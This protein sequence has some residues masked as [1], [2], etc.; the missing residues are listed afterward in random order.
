MNRI[1][2][3]IPLLSLLLAACT[4]LPKVCDYTTIQ[5]D[6]SYTY[7]GEMLH[8]RKH[9]Y[10]ILAK[11]DSIVYVGFW[12]NGIRHGKGR[13]TDSR[14]R[15]IQGKFRGD[16]LFWGERKDSFGVYRGQMNACG[17][18]NGHG[19]YSSFD[20]LMYE[21]RWK[22]DKEDGFGFALTKHN[23]LKV[24]EWKAGVFKGEKLNYT[25]E[26]IYGIDISHYQHVIRKKKYNIDWANLRITHLG[27][28]SKKKITG[29]VNYPVSFIY[30]KSTE[31][32]TI[33]NKFYPGDYVQARRHGYR[34]GSYHFYSTISPALAQA[35]SFVKRS[36][37]Q[38]GDLP[39]VL[40]LEPSD[41]QIAKVGGSKQLFKGVRTWLNYVHAAW[42]V[43][44]I[45]YISQSF[46]NK[47]LPQAPDLKHNYRVWIAR[48]GE[49]KP[50]IKL[51]YW[52]LSPDGRV[53]G[54]HGLVDIN[55]FNGYQDEWNE[56]I[57]QIW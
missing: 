53:R 47:H 6:D 57:G 5:Q 8:G 24:G 36:R 35:K 1:I 34:V 51:I 28:L 3:V 52:Q 30:M 56:Y 7:Q 27:R 22:N 14:Q 31:G 55:V 54:I 44:P 29:K 37:Y 50:D 17:M 43:R 45:L 49:Y 25:S 16:T 48:Y 19:T 26:R 15:V 39:P 33:S 13:I 32:I 10:G 11:G 23:H 21:G 4:N 12:E 9:G 40:D 18:A 41:K 38:A 42:G 20:G 46:V 2:K